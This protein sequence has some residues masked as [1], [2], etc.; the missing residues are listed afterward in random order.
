MVQVP[1]LVWAVAQEAP[2]A[3]QELAKQQASPAQVE[4]GQHA[5]P[6][7]PQ[8][9]QTPDTWLQAVLTPV[10]R[11][12]AQQASPARPQETQVLVVLLQRLPAPVQALPGQQGWPT[13]PQVPHEPAAHVPGCFT[14]AVP[15][16]TQ[17]QPT[18]HPP[19]R[20]PVPG[21]QG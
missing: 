21:Q 17:E 2:A 5:L 13:P 8:G 15:S 7:S 3:T 12:F 9:A 16:A 14:Q 18:Q 4:P 19:P 11:L 6:G 10:Q 20:Q 1:A